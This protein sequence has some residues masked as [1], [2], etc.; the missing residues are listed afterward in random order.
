MK[1]V[2]HYNA[3]KKIRDILSNR[4]DDGLDITICAEEDVSFFLEEI[5]DAEIIWHVLKPLTKEIISSASKLKLIQKMGVGINTI[6][7]DTA[8]EKNISVCNMPGSNS[9]AVAEMTL[10]LILTLYRKLLLLDKGIRSNL[11]NLDDYLSDAREISGKTVGFIGFG[12]IPRILAPILELMGAEIIYTSSS[13][14]VKNFNKV[15]L[16]L[17]LKK[18]DIVSLHIPYTRDNFNFINDD[19]L[20]IMKP[21]S[22]LINTARGELIDEADLFEHLKNGNL[23]GAALDVFSEEPLPMSS[24]LRSL[25]NIILTPHTAWRTE[26]TLERSIGIALKNS[27]ALFNNKEL[28]SKIN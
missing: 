4:P 20:K 24:S 1:V 22:I 2:F 26:E 23:A 21:N 25:D 12:S 8:N 5:K 18:S 19:K 11:W 27:L 13:K 9:K 16:D 7:I 14:K 15:S 28:Y 10:M 6:D 17:L 3:N